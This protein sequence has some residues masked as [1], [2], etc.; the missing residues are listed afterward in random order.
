LLG[1][2]RLAG[3]REGEAGGAEGAPSPSAAASPRA[4]AVA[5][6]GVASGEYTMSATT[7]SVARRARSTSRAS[8]P[9]M[10]KVV[11]FTSSRAPASTSLR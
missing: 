11:V 10:P 1:E 5:S 7:A 4:R 6:N 8:W 2:A 3:E 9:V